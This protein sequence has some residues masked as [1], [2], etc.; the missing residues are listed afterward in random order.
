MN[1]FCEEKPFYDLIQFLPTAAYVCSADGKITHYNRRAVE[2][3]GCEPDLMNAQVKYGVC[4]KMFRPDGSAISPEEF[5]MARVLQTGED[6]KNVELDVERPDG[7]YFTAMINVT[8]VL[9]S[10]GRVT[11]AINCFQ[12]ITDRKKMENALRLSERKFRSLIDQLPAAAYVCDKNGLITHYNPQA[13]ELWGRAPEINDSQ[14]RYCASYKAYQPD[15]KP[16]FIDEI[17]M[18]RVLKTGEPVRDAEIILERPDGSRLTC[19]VNIEPLK[20]DTGRLTGA[21]NC[22]YNI[23]PRKQVEL[24]LK[25][26]NEEIAHAKNI[27]E[28]AS[29][30][31]SEFL[32][33]ISHEIRTPLTAIMGFANFLLDPLLSLSERVETAG[34]I[35][36]NSEVLMRLINDL[37]DLSK[38]EAGHV[39][40]EKM[41]FSLEEL[42]DD[43]RAILQFK[44]QEKGIGLDIV[45]KTRPAG[46]FLGDSIKLRQILMNI[47]GNAIKFTE[48]GYVQCEIRV[49]PAESGRMLLNFLIRDTGVGIS[50]EQCER[51]FKPFVQADLSL[52]R[53]YGGTGLG[54]FISR[55]LAE[56][57]GGGIR[58][59]ESAPETGSLFEIT[60]EVEAAE[61]GP[62][63][64][65]ETERQ[66]G[67]FS[68]PLQTPSQPLIG[69]R[70]LL[71]EDTPDN[72]ILMRKT[73]KNLGVRV[74]VA[75]NG[76]EAV[77]KALV[78][79]Y[80]VILMDLQMPELDGYEATDRLREC[81]YDRPI[82]ALTAHAMRDER[83]KALKSGFNDYL[84]KP[85][86]KA[87]LIATLTTWKSKKSA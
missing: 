69:T 45:F 32:A 17:P 4:K 39:E 42:A 84:T 66:D 7:S 73:L 50:R 82:I 81:R 31:K 67:A 65:S 47:I 57:L 34:I 19:M 35:K 23:T 51:I 58:L 53:K 87:A 18:A 80:D 86:D 63:D 20:D 11:G 5:P 15:G 37:L 85:L 77:E 41:P 30:A 40:I 78:G 75:S 48:K 44:A 70:L 64:T 38:I 33:N 52:S 3:W 56:R 2:S 61:M 74:D 60:V 8:P 55:R 62:R 54:L 72:Q 26:A 25:Q 29:H 76:S 59:I 43:I 24:V 83:Q 68:L 14:W 27:A 9:D 16:L 71:A 6:L 49:L 28:A 1:H 79:D 12:D 36:R 22:F 10:E 21:I 46:K 13:V